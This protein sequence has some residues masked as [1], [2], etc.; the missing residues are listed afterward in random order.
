MSEKMFIRLLRLYPSRFRKEY[1]DEARQLVR[2][3][4]RDERGFY[5]RGRL[6]WDLMAD[7][8][9]GLPQ[10]YRNANGAIEAA[11]LSLHAEGIPSFRILDEEPIG[12][13][14]ILLGS[15]LSL[16]T[17]VAFGFLL[18]RPMAHLRVP[19]SNGR[20]SPIE[21][22]VE[23]LNQAA[24]RDIPTSGV[25]KVPASTSVEASERQPQPLPAAAASPSTSPAPVLLPETVSVAGR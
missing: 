18:S 15:T 12:R 1:D 23:R 2:D 25:E 9:T 22:V 13:G 19:G 7:G 3:R 17:I 5:K 21:A 14:S 4:L 20:M 24:T 6:L 10:A 11:P 8:F 16:S